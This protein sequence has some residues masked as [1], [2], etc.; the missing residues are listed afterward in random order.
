MLELLC[1]SPFFGLALTLV[2][3]CIGAACQSCWKM[4]IL[5]PILISAALSILALYV[6]D[7]PV[8]KYRQDCQILTYMITPATICLAISFYEQLQNLKKHLP[9]ILIGVFGGA[10]SS[11]LSVWVLCRLFGFDQVMTVSLLPKS[12]TAAI[13]VALSEQAGGVGALTTVVIS[14]TGILGNVI[15]PSLAKLL[16]LR[17]PISQGVAFGTSSHVIGTSRA[18]EISELAG[19]VG[20]LSLTLAGLITTVLL[21]FFI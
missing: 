12:V 3:F 17:D 4:P 19:A 1:D 10:L 21:S 20:S 15:G 9:A 2:T 18:M 7:V 14:A 13:G 16:D 5:N 6:L 8:E 11:L